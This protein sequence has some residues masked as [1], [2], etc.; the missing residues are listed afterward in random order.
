MLTEAN[1][2]LRKE[3]A[4]KEPA[5]IGIA[6]P[7]V[8]HEAQAQ[9]VLDGIPAW[10]RAEVRLTFALTKAGVADIAVALRLDREAVLLITRTNPLDDPRRHQE[11]SRGKDGVKFA[12]EAM[13]YDR[14]ISGSSARLNALWE[15]T[16]S[17]VCEN[18]KGNPLIDVK[19]LAPEIGAVVDTARK[20]NDAVAAISPATRVAVRLAFAVNRNLEIGEIAEALGQDKG[21]V[22]RLT[23]NGPGESG[24]MNHGDTGIQ[25]TKDLFMSER[26][27][28]RGSAI[29][30]EAGW[31]RALIVVRE[32]KSRLLKDL[33]WRL[34]DL[35]AKGR[36]LGNPLLVSL[37]AA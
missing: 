34:V 36:G 21:V 35:A 29:M 31:L 16:L 5:M 13:Q 1:R 6:R 24:A 28:G 7:V 9:G 3:S 4:P 23:R 33:D 37:E 11:M 19:A 10:Q 25:Q 2:A 15:E 14:R 22:H 20:L 30:D 27:V 32:M 8:R 26:A 17:E 12:K 18:S